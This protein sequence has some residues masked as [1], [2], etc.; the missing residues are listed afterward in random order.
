MTAAGSV[1]ISTFERVSG[2]RLAG[3]VGGL[4]GH[5]DHRLPAGKPEGARGSN[6]CLS[7]GIT[8]LAPLGYTVCNVA[9][10]HLEPPGCPMIADLSRRGP[11]GCGSVPGGKHVLV[12]FG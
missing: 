4:H 12:G 7:F 9:A 1:C 11:H 3:V 8:L 10:G 5:G 6:L 2:A